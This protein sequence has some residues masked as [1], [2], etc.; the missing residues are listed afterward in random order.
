MK[1]FKEE[2]RFTQWW[3]WVII[4]GIDA[5][6]VY[7]FVQQFILKK[8][9]GDNPMPNVIFILTLLLVIA[10][11]IFFILLKLETRIDNNGIEYRFY[12]I[13]KQKIIAWK[14]IQSIKTI[15]YRPILDYGGWGIK[16]DAYT[17]KGN[18]G[19]K[20]HFKSGKTMLIGTQK[21]TEAKQVLETYKPKIQQQ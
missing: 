16:G 9:F 11:T 13:T 17:T 10:L 5:L 14:E 7:G 8:P 2:Q 1:V 15:T 12:P 6:F 4:L 18:K 21:E 20:I 3:L 19:I